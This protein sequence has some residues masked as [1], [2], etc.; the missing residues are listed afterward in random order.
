MS[1][2]S[3]HI[4]LNSQEIHLWMLNPLSIQASELLHAY[5]DLLNDEEKNKVDRYK[6]AEHRHDALITRA[7]LRDTLA[8]YL[9]QD[10][11]TIHF[12]KGEHGKPELSPAND[13]SFNLSHTDGLII[14]AISKNVALGADCENIERSNDILAIADRY[15]SPTEVK[16][17]FSLPTDHQRS[18]F[19]DY[20]TLKE[21]YIKACGQ[22]LAIPLDHFS[23]T[24]D[25]KD[26]NSINGQ[27]K[28][29]IALD[30][31]SER[32]D[33]AEYW[34]SWLLYPNESHRMALSIKTKSA[35]ESRFSLRLFTS[36][37]LL[38]FDEI[39]LEQAPLLVKN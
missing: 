2:N 18:R 29:E 36:T 30:F 24:I 8:K 38:Q 22:G 20:W 33:Q 39:S 26:A 11:K 16:A 12:T 7:F 4:T 21:S 3:K 5:H 14:L 28:T 31:V 6:F 10:A 34:Q 9:A 17:L 32:N 27:I 35:N 23:F 19:F 15:F 1:S 37:P 13:I 25:D